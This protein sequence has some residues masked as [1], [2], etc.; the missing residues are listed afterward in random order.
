MIEKHIQITKTARYYISG[1][2]ENATEVW[3]LI[4]GYA[5]S[6]AEMIS[7]FETYA[8][9]GR[10]FVAPEGLS[11]FYSRGF[12]GKPVASWMTS[13]DR[14]NEIND[15]VKYLDQV[16]LEIIPVEFKGEINLLGFSQGVATATRWMNATQFKVSHL[17]IYAGRIASELV[18]PISPIFSKCHITY[19]TG[20]KDKLISNED[21]AAVLN[22]MKR[23]NARIIHFD[24]GHEIVPEALNQFIN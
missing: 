10:L 9:P 13:E 23:L 18:E 12:G 17:Y 1:D 15:Y 16:L 5:H 7:H 4:H 24:G 6:G 2:I 14:L 21:Q 11:R 3:M 8:K 20:D 19:I 22:L